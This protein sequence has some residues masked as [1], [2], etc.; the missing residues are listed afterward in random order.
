MNDLIARLRGDILSRYCRFFRK[1]IVI[2][3]GLKLLA[4]LEIEGE[5]KIPMKTQNSWIQSNQ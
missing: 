4:K 2:G 5:G 1:N 3:S